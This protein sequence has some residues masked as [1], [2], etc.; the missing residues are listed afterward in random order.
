MKKCLFALLFFISLAVFGQSKITV[1]STSDRVP[2]ANAEIFC[3]QKLA[4]NTDKNGVLNFKTKCR[5]VSVKA[6]GYYEDD[7]VVDK[8]MEVALSK[9]DPK[10]QSIEG[11]IIAY[12][13]DPRA[14][15]I[16]KK[17]NDNYKTNSPKSLDSYSFKSYEKISFDLDEDSIQLYNQSLDKMIDSLKTLPKPVQTAEQKKDSLETESVMKLAGQSKLFLWERASE[18][19]FSKKY[20]E[21]V[22]ILDN[23]ISGLQQPVYELLS[24][25]SNRNQVP[26]EIREENRALYRFFL[27]DS[28]TIDGRKNYVIRFR[29]ADFKK[30]VQR[31]K[32]NGYLYIDAANYALKKIESNSKVKSAGSITSIWTPI[33]NKWFL[34]Q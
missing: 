26:R 2:L 20:G 24:L 31:R 25:R 16:L 33:D 8:I 4:G 3:N 10:T 29:Q 5:K 19:L 6:S 23:R 34:L 13:S 32:F 7:V 17:V 21:K 18:F 27:T 30:P 1:F 22:N 14:L 28:I 9:T 11:V 12:K 15:A